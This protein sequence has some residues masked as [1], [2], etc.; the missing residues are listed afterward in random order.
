M[1]KYRVL[2]ANIPAILAIAIKKI[3]E[4]TTNSLP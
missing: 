4:F 2:K 3:K 1:A